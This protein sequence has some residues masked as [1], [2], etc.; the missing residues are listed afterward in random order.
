MRQ[1]IS[2]APIPCG[3]RPFVI[4]CYKNFP[5]AHHVSHIGLGVSAL[6][7]AKVLRSKGINADVWAILG[8]KTIADR[9]K[10]SP[11]RPTH[12]VIGA[13]WIPTLDLQVLVF[14]HPDI[15]FSVVCHSNVGFLQNDP[16]AITNFRQDLA[17]EQGALNFRAAGNSQRL[18]SWIES[19]YERPCLWLPNLYF[20][21]RQDPVYRRPWNGSF[22]RIGAFGAVRALKNLTSA[23]AA[24]LKLAEG[25]HVQLEFHI[26]VGRV[27]GGTTVV[28]A[29]RAMLENVPCVSLVEDPWFQWPQFRQVI[30]S[31][32]LLMQ[33]SYTESFNMVTAD[34]AAESIPSV[35]SDAIDW[36]PNDWKADVDDA[37]DIAK[38]AQYLLHHMHAGAE[39][40][41]ALQKHNR[42]GARAWMEYLES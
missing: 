36:A 30:R 38:T 6:N 15:E 10:T 2:T 4:L 13:P 9:I 18:C 16:Q 21:D 1:T 23:A 7:T 24:A 26:S 28:R 42:D 3:P 8:A 12:I 19:A 39:G 22:L 33:P 41:R 11:I 29:L 31:M 17:L 37:L 14:G 32:D 40:F 35:V 5:V 34:G 27:E 25:L 20:L